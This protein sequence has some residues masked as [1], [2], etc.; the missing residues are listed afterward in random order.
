[1]WPVTFEVRTKEPPG[2]STRWHSAN[3]ASGS[4]KLLT[5]R[6]ETTSSNAESRN[7]SRAPSP[8]A[9]AACG[10]RHVSR[11]CSARRSASRQGSSPTTC[12][13][14]PSRSAS[15]SS[16][17]P[18][19]QPKSSARRAVSGTCSRR[20]W[21]ASDDHSGS[22]SNSATSRS[23]SSSKMSGADTLRSALEFVDLPPAEL[24]EVVV[25]LHDVLELLHVLLAL[26]LALE[27][28]LERLEARHFHLGD[29]RPVAFGAHVCEHAHLPHAHLLA[30][31]GHGQELL[32]HRTHLAGLAVH[33]VADE[34]HDDS[35]CWSVNGRV[36]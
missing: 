30:E 17:K 32:D 9:M 20:S 3:T 34:Q 16:G 12:A 1:M 26:A 18:A 33:D 24:H 6:F 23:A 13:P 25:A 21:P 8:A 2:R 10:T 29:D 35:S 11:F 4:A 14:G 22:S 15:S 7:G 27:H 5:P 28:L 31:L 19:P 36:A